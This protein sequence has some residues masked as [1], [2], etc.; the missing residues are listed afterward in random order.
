MFKNEPLEIALKVL[1]SDLP[2]LQYNLER[3]FDYQQKRLKA[4][5]NYWGVNDN[6]PIV[7]RSNFIGFQVPQKAPSRFLT[8]SGT[9]SKSFR[10]AI[11]Q[12]AFKR[13]EID[14]HYRYILD[15]FGIQKNNPLIL[16]VTPFKRL[17]GNTPIRWKGY[18]FWQRVFKPKTGNASYSHGARSATCIHWMYNHADLDAFCNFLWEHLKGGL[19]YDV[20]VSAFSFL[21]M[22]LNY[23][24]HR[25][26]KIS[27]LLSS[28]FE[29]PIENE[30]DEL[31]ENNYFDHFC[32]HMRG[33]DGGFT[34]ITC[35]YRRKHILDYL[36]FVES[37]CNKLISTDFFNFAMPFIRY[38]NGDYIDMDL[39][40]KK[41]ECGRYYRNINDFGGRSSFVIGNKKKISSIQIYDMVTQLDCIT[42]A[43][44]RD[45]S[46]EIVTM[47]PLSQSQKD[48]LSQKIPIPVK[49]SLRNF[50]FSGRFNKVLRVVNATGGKYAQ[51]KRTSEKS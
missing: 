20:F 27:R 22:F 8:T 25:P 38:A 45:D 4:I 26:V 2:S 21:S 9:Y 49:F 39:E 37:E 46:I 6:P 34:F 36:S 48:S 31:L 51:S 28:T 1:D 15:E 5:Q 7:D 43:I 16:R 18:R 3:L 35:R 14:L 42:Q 17:S 30:V 32:D 41:C 33:W 50:Q 47:R 10:Y 44:C 24:E 19:P 40:W 13:I 29:S 11:W 23:T 12:K